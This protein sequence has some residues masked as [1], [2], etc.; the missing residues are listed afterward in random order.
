MSECK[1]CQKQG[2]EQK[3]LVDF[4]EG[5]LIGGNYLSVSVE[6]DGQLN[7]D[8]G[9]QDIFESPMTV[10]TSVHINYCPMCGRKLTEV[11]E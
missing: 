3:L 6:H 1:Y 4:D 8:W 2:L 5:D 9:G 10:E 7:C 11:H